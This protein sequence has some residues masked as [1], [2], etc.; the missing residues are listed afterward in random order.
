VRLNPDF[1]GGSLWDIGVYPLSYAQFVLGGPPEAVTG[2]QVVG[3]S[4]VDESFAGEMLYSGGRLGQLF[5][6]FRLPFQSTIEILGTAGRLVL[7]RP[8]VA[9]DD[10]PSFTLFLTEGEPEEIPAPVEELYLGEVEDL[11]ASLLD[12]ARPYLSL[13]ETRAHVRTAL[14]LYEAAR[15]GQKVEID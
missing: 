11:H 10:R 5:C 6:S 1:G 13:E 4:G 2:F 14:A 3:A 15:T 12:G 8:F 9:V 7:T